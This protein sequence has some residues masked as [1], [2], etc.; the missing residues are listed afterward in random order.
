MIEEPEVG[1]LVHLVS[2]SPIMTISEVTEA[3]VTVLW[4]NDRLDAQSITAPAACFNPIPIP[5]V[6]ATPPSGE[7]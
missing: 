3:R 7:D 4:V 5:A 6:P 1:M 2:G